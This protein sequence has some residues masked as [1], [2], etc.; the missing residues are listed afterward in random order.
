M[1]QYLIGITKDL[2]Q[3]IANGNDEGL[4]AEEIACYD[5]LAANES[6]VEVMGN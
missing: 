2:Q 3:S 4:T 6:A 5:T 1:I